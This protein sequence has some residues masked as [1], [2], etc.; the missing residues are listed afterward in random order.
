MYTK[1]YRQRSL[2]LKRQLHLESFLDT[3]ISTMFVELGW[4]PLASFTETMCDP[5]VRMFYSNII[6]HDLDESYLKSSL[7]RIVVKVTLEVIAKVLGIPLVEA[8]SVSDLEITYELLDRVFIDLWG[9]VRG[10][11]GSVVHISSISC[12]AWVLATFLTFSVYLSS[13]RADICKKGC[14]IL[15][16]F[17]QREPINLASSIL[18]EMIV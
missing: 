1:D 7:F 6:E 8:P 16:E 11:L 4:L 18:E 9:K 15:S 13:H 3:P 14:I 5:I 2:V 17:L 10:Q 12:H